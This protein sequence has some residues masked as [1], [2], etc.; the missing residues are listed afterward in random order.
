MNEHVKR[1]ILIVEDDEMLIEIYKKKF[2]KGDFEL[3][4]VKDGKQA[5]REAKSKKPD[6]ILL[7][8]V[9]PEIDGFQALSFLKEDPETKDIKVVITSN[10]SQESEKRKAMELGAADFLVKSNF[11][12]SQLAEKIREYIK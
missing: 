4:F 12:L 2:E 3:I 7:D 5:M 9:M 10:I 8:L 6:L 1:K 11:D